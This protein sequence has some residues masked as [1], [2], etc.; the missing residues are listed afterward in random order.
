MNDI[1]R[2][3]AL[4]GGKRRGG[5]RRHWGGE[6]ISTRDFQ[7]CHVSY[8][9]VLWMASADVVES[10]YGVR[11]ELPQLRIL[12]LGF[13]EDR[14]VGV[15]VFP[16]REKFPVHGLAFF[17]FADGG[18]GARKA[19]MGEGPVDCGLGDTGVFEYL[20]EFRRSFFSGARLKISQAP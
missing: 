14:K 20:A 2:T 6:Q 15:G 10:G 13:F 18:I 11:Y 1:Q 16:K 4:L 8:S 5:G 9:S 7:G 12:G 17:G 3:G 19:E